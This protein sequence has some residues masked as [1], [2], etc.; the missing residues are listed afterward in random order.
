MTDIISGIYGIINEN[1]N[2]IINNNTIDFGQAAVLTL[3]ASN[4][5]LNDNKYL[6]KKIQISHNKQQI[7]ATIELDTEKYAIPLT[8]NAFNFNLTLDRKENSIYEFNSKTFTYQHKQEQQKPSLPVK[9]LQKLSGQTYNVQFT[10]YMSGYIPSTDFLENKLPDICTVTT[11]FFG[12]LF[13]VDNTEQSYRFNSIIRSVSGITKYQLCSSIINEI[14]ASGDIA[15]LTSAGLTE[16]PATGNV[17]IHGQFD[18]TDDF[19]KKYIVDGSNI[20]TIAGNLLS[21]STTGLITSNDIVSSITTG[22]FN[23]L[24]E[25]ISALYPGYQYVEG[26]SSIVTTQPTSSYTINSATV[27]GDFNITGNVT[28]N[29]QLS[30]LSA[31]G[32]QLSSNII[33][34]IPSNSVLAFDGTIKN[35]QTDYTYEYVYVQQTASQYIQ[36]IGSAIVTSNISYML[37]LLS[38]SAQTSIPILTNSDNDVVLYGNI[39]QFDYH[40]ALQINPLMHSNSA[41]IYPKNNTDKQ[42]I[43]GFCSGTDISSY[44]NMVKLDKYPDFNTHYLTQQ[45]AINTEASQLYNEDLIIPYISSNIINDISGGIS[46]LP[47]INEN[48]GKLH[49]LI[50]NMDPYNFTQLF[51]FVVKMKNK[52]YTSNSGLI[53][54]L[55]QGT[56]SWYPSSGGLIGYYLPEIYQTFFSDF[57]QPYI[58]LSK[59]L[60][61]NGQQFDWSQKINDQYDFISYV[62]NCDIDISSELSKEYLNN[63]KSSR[64]LCFVFNNKITD[65]TIES[66][67]TK[68]TSNNIEELQKFIKCMLHNIA[69]AIN[70]LPKNFYNRD[71]YII[72]NISNTSSFQIDTLNIQLDKQLIFSNLYNCNIYIQNI[73]ENIN[74]NISSATHTVLNLINLD[75]VYLTNIEFTSC[76]NYENRIP[77]TP[78]YM[79]L[80]K[81]INVKYLKSD[82]CIYDNIIPRVIQN[83]IFTLEQTLL[84]YPTYALIYIN[85][86]KLQLYN[87]TLRN[88]NHGIIAYCNSDVQY[89]GTT[90]ILFNSIQVYKQNNELLSASFVPLTGHYIPIL[91][92]DYAKLSSQILNYNGN[93]IYLTYQP[94]I[95]YT[96]GN[97]R[98]NCFVDA[99]HKFYNERISAD[100]TNQEI[101]YLDENQVNFKLGISQ[102]GSIFNHTHNGLTLQT[103]DTG[104]IDRLSSIIDMMKTI[105]PDPCIGMSNPQLPINLFETNDQ[106]KSIGYTYT[107]VSADIN[108]ENNNYIKYQHK[109]LTQSFPLSTYNCISMNYNKKYSFI[110]NDDQYDDNAIMCLSSNSFSSILGKLYSTNQVDTDDSQI[111]NNGQFW[112]KMV[113]D[114]SIIPNYAIINDENI[115]NIDSSIISTS[116]T[117]FTSQ[118]ITNIRYACLVK[119]YFSDDT[120]LDDWVIPGK[121]S[122]VNKTNGVGL[123]THVKQYTDYKQDVVNLE[124]N[125]SDRYNAA[126]RKRYSN[127][128]G[129][130]YD[131]LYGQGVVQF[132]QNKGS[133]GTIMPSCQICYGL[134]IFYQRTTNDVNDFAETKIE[135][136]LAMPMLISG[137]PA[138]TIL[139]TIRSKY[140]LNMPFPVLVSSWCQINTNPFNYQAIDVPFKFYNTNANEISNKSMYSSLSQLILNDSISTDSISALNE[141]NNDTYKRM[142]FNDNYY[143]MTDKFRFYTKTTKLTTIPSFCDGSISASIFKQLSGNTYE[144]VNQYQSISGNYN[145]PDITDINNFKQ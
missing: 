142:I 39:Q 84:A 59:T 13:N 117:Y 56:S 145:I 9:L 31:N 38:V 82:N 18:Y 106:N 110:M 49:K 54:Q 5:I 1:T 138:E 6:V 61:H 80:I 25:Q 137:F 127:A 55:Q 60:I 135:D 78:K 122:K 89:T 143:G 114:K 105:T 40:I 30:V 113:V 97:S 10:T 24:P 52:S 134:P 86:T 23:C 67:Y 46:N 7:S 92:S 41:I 65:K 139:P 29:S 112:H 140:D 28:K 120:L 96:A 73:S 51:K 115:L 20:V 144:L 11:T 32:M 8:I 3:D 98:C 62:S 99:N 79:Q 22:Y 107:N 75:N 64:D 104:V 125:I 45:L 68:T 47:D 83:N 4:I 33:K 85:N 116:G 12:R 53:Q 87:S 16:F 129:E 27:Y 2:G 133:A 17:Q 101:N 57:K 76:Y 102:L 58:G 111:Y 136:I 14:P 34:N 118:N 81:S 77:N 108:S 123:L 66:K 36:C 63:K 35:A 72:F 121:I 126:I 90:K 69:N 109:L 94:I 15:N 131:N 48:T 50:T 124:I 19:N 37:G 141:N 132:R 42:N 74:I 95:N 43:I 21:S 119:N 71:I 93:G 26:T 103:M 44:I 100:I 88:S 130:R 128:T 91:K 70:K